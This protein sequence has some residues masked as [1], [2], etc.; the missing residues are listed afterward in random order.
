[1]KIAK[2]QPPLYYKISYCRIK[3]FVERKDILQKID[4]AFFNRT[5]LNYTILQGL[6]NQNKT[7][8]ALK[9][10]KKRNN[11]HLTILWVNAIT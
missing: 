10:L 11:P 5:D 4:K 2:K 1:M 3:V 6:S 9:Y 7:Q 8:V